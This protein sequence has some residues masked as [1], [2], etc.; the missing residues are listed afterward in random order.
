MLQLA[1][2]HRSLRLLLADTATRKPSAAVAQDVL[3]GILAA[4]PAVQQASV[5]T[6]TAPPPPAA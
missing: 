5:T 6:P 1:V 3:A 2:G 4:L